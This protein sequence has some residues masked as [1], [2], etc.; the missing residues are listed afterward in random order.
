MSISVTIKGIDGVVVELG[1]FGPQLAR[2][3][4]LDMSQIAFDSMQEGAARHSKKGNL[5]ASVFNRPTQAGREVGHDLQRAPHA[6]FVVFG[7]R[8]HIIRPKEKK[9]LRWVSGNGFVFA[10]VV[11]HPGYRGDNYL[12]T[13]ATDAIKAFPGIVDRAIKEQ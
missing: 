5:L 10:R 13:A 6:P 3:V 7:T 8:P 11:N 12:E 4:V 9:A 2:R 1:K